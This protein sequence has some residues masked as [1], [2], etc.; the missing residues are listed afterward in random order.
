MATAAAT[1]ESTI[2]EGWL[3]KKGGYRYKKRFCVLTSR[4]LRYALNGETKKEKGG[5]RDQCYG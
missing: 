2:K 3:S 5:G 4:A 1:M